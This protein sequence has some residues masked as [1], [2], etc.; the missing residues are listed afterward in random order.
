MLLKGNPNHSPS[1]GRFTSASGA[2]ASRPGYVPPSA[3]EKKAKANAARRAKA[4]NSRMNARLT[5]WY[6]ANGGMPT[7]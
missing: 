5:A 1:N 6:M 2:S 7:P 3:A 4:A